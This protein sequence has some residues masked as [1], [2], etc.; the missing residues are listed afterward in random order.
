MKSAL[1]IAGSDPTGAA[2]V[3][4]DLKTFSVLGVYGMAA[5][6]A[7]TV[8]STL[9]IRETVLLEPD[10]VRK[11]ID[12]VAGDLQSEAVKT[13]L[14]GSAAVIEAVEDS[15]SRNKLQPYVCDASMI[16]KDGKELLTADGVA[17]LKKKLFPIATVVTFTLAEAGAVAGFEKGG[18][19][20]VVLM[21]EAA[22]KIG[23]MGAKAVVIKGATVGEQ[24]VDVFF[25]GRE[26]TE[27]GAKTQPPEK[28]HGSGTAF[29]AAITAG[30]AEGKTLVEAIDQAKQLVNMAIQ[31]S[32]GTGRG[33]SPVNVLAF[34]AKKK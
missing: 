20:S 7:I 33:T 10:L 2:G 8:Q 19:N 18:V 17:M 11:Q 21:K 32:D 34:K 30:L 14:L 22:R 24:T 31:Y 15:L 23:G 1:T 29:S 3:Q 5:V 26:F 12:A 9:G 6:T 27:F 13:G 28:S 25:D 16:G 4:G